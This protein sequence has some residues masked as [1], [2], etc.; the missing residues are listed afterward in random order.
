MSTSSPN[1][2]Y[3]STE[4]QVLEG[5]SAVR[6]RPSMYIGSTDVHGLHHCVYEVLD[7]SIDEALAGYCSLIKVVLKHNDMILVEDNG[8]GIPVEKHPKYDMSAVEVVLTKLHAGGKFQQG[9][10]KVSG[11]LHGVGISCVN[12]LSE[13]MRVQ[14]SRDHAI[15]E[16]E[17]SRGTVTKP[18]TPIGNTQSTGTLV[19]FK[20]DATLFETTK[21]NADVITK[22]LMELAFLNKGLKIEFR[23][24]RHDPVKQ[25]T[26][27]FKG[28]LISFVEHLNKSKK[29]LTKEPM[30]FQKDMDSLSIEIALS[31]TTGYNEVF[32]SY[33]N[34]V[35]TSAGG[36]HVNGF[37]MGLLR[38]FN[39]FL[40]TYGLDKKEQISF[41]SDDV[42]EGLTG[43]LSVKMPDPQFDGQTKNRLGNSDVQKDVKDMV[44]ETPSALLWDARDGRQNHHQQSHSSHPSARS[45]QES[46]RTHP[47]EVR[48]DEW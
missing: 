34:N 18:L 25:K 41:L 28:G 42:R 10:Y 29:S 13:Y 33:V 24:E 43:I 36:T 9:A 35:E 12:A 15:H 1:N 45:R 44:E 3:G 11:G 20:A 39:K 4:I 26:Y 21:V 6:K 38:V 22:R 8:R 27:Y 16:I 40:R 19:E 7:N 5:L 47:K 14:V 31:Y 37:K 17:L 30:Y 46:K 48:L 23:D 32:Y 2:P